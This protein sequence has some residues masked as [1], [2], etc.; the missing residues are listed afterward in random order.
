LNN[1]VRLPKKSLDAIILA[2]RNTFADTDHLWIFGS[3][4][5]LTARGGDIDLYIETSN[6]DIDDVI[7]RKSKMITSIWRAIG[8]QKVDV[9]LNILSLQHNLPIYRLAKDQGVQLA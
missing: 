8:E 6:A 1:K 4:I 5:D 7:V 9:V 2:F 3:R